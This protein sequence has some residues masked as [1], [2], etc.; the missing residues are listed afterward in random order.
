MDELK[1]IGTFMDKVGRF[2]QVALLTDEEVGELFGEETAAV[3]ATF[4]CYSEENGLCA[5]CGG[6]C[7]REI[8]CEVY[9]PLF[10]ECPIHATRPLLCRFHFC[11]SF[12]AADKG[13]VIELRDVF[14]GCYTADQISSGTVSRSMNVPP[15]ETA[16]PVLVASIQPIMDAVREGRLDPRDGVQSIQ[17]EVER[18]RKHHSPSRTRD[19]VKDSSDGAR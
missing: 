9:S 13:L 7:C 14:L 15:L 8:G 1:A 2:S 12:D 18:Y 19:P 6:V 5:S 4:E 16:C 3:L 11:H 17:Q 10:Q